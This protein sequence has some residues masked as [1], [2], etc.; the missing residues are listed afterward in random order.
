MNVRF[1]AINARKRPFRYPPVLS[2]PT[3]IMRSVVKLPHRAMRRS[4]LI[5]GM[6]WSN[7]APGDICQDG[8][9]EDDHPVLYLYRQIIRVPAKDRRFTS[10]PAFDPR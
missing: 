9:G 1:S 6:D 5:T 4:F 8:V 2:S 7:P 3:D 10:L